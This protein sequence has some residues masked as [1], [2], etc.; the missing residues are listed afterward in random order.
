MSNDKDLE[1][2]GWLWGES[3]NALHVST[4]PLII[5]Q[6]PGQDFWVPR[7]LVGYHKKSAEAR[8]TK[9][10]FTLPEW[11]IEQAQMWDLVP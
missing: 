10:I 11:K 4:M 6:S 2:R 5:G 9:I 8:G 7:S 3:P 1:C